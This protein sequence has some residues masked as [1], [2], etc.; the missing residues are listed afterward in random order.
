M[1]NWPG[2][3]ASPQGRQGIAFTLPPFFS[4]QHDQEINCE[5]FCQFLRDEIPLT[6]L[7]QLRTDP[8]IVLN[9]NAMN[10]IAARGL[11][12]WDTAKPANRNTHLYHME[13]LCAY[14]AHA[15]TQHNNERLVKLGALMLALTIKSEI[16][17]SVFAIVSNDFMQE[18]TDAKEETYPEEPAN[19]PAE[20]PTG[21]VEDDDGPQRRKRGNRRGKKKLLDLHRVVLK[22]EKELL[23]VAS[24]LGPEKFLKRSKSICESLTSKE[25]NLRERTGKEKSKQLMARIDETIPPNYRQR[26]QG[27]DLPP[28]LLGYF[29]YTPIGLKANVT[30]LKKELEAREISFDRRLTVTRKAKIL[31]EN[32]PRRLERQVEDKLRTRGYEWTGLKLP[33]KIQLLKQDMEDKEEHAGGE[34]DMDILKYFKLVSS[35]I[36]Q[37]NL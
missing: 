10:E 37:I 19:Q 2:G 20:A 30:G 14:A 3:G 18:Y 29:P 9:R 31:K 23:E 1:T 7:A 35:S 4:N 34:Y 36:D 5:K 16:M 33:A 24:H 32:K 11:D 22:K 8:C 6:V 25:E 15:S 26:K 17:S 27:D 28:R 13:A 12:I 21:G